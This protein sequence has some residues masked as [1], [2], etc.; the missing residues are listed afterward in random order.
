MKLV[1][2]IYALSLLR[3]IH[4]DCGVDGGTIVVAN[5]NYQI[6]DELEA[7]STIFGDILIDPAFVY[8]IL[9]G[10]QEITGTIIAH[11]NVILKSLGLPDVRKLGGF[12]FASPT[13]STPISFPEV[14]EI[15]NLEWRNITWQY[16]DD[17][18]AWSADKFVAVSNLDVEGTYL[19]GFMP[20]YPSYDNSYYYYGGLVQLETADNVRVVDNLRMDKV[21]FQGLKTISGSL[22]VGS[23]FNFQNSRGKRDES[24]LLV[25]LPALESV[26]NAVIYD[27]DNIYRDLEGGKI[28][29]PVLGHVYGDLNVTNIGGIADVSVPA[30][31]DIDGGLY[32]LG[33]RGLKT[34]NFPEL[35]RV[36]HV[37]IDGG[38]SYYGGFEK[39][40]FP[41]LEEVGVFHVNAPAYVFDCSS[42]DHIREIASEFSC[43]NSEGTYDPDAPSSTS[44]VP[45]PTP[46]DPGASSTSEPSPSNEP[47]LTSEPSVTSGPVTTDE[48]SLTSNP[49]TEDKPSVTS[50]PVTTDQPGQTDTPAPIGSAEST[51]KTDATGGTGPTPTT[52]SPADASGSEPASSS[53]SS[54]KSPFWIFQ[55]FIKS[56]F[57]VI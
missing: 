40:S 27:D 42:L 28:D 36:N 7:C 25:S 20:D 48:P 50:G 5:P 41:A 38:D 14:I 51:T 37:I 31:T 19:S 33:N 46:S 17:Y 53:A 34:L 2:S 24:G 52:E 55:W 1:S 4:A 35:H 26:G 21:V 57:L 45:T 6:L 18:F 8:F 10:P 11:D 23:N 39:I 47:S 13:I 44:E 56:L 16:E 3:V 29:L 43:S 54:L 30:L 32:I 9:Q 12:S 15:G 22:V 49:A